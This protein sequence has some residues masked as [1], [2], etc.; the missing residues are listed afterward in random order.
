[1]NSGM[2]VASG[3]LAGGRSEGISFSFGAGLGGM[4][5]VVAGALG[6]SATVLARAEL[7]TVLKLVGADYLVWLGI[8]TFQA[9][10]RDAASAFGRW[11]SQAAYRSSQGIREGVMARP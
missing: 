10:R 6:V 3:T 2:Y 7:C 1:M 8:R 5:H 4:V 9:A 11:R